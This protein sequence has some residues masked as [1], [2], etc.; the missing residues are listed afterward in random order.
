MGRQADRLEEMADR[1]ADPRTLLQVPPVLT[2][3]PARAVTI[4]RR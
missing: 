1:L 3:T 4:E 2:L